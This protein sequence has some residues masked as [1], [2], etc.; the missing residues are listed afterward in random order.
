MFDIKKAIKQWQKTLRKNEAFEDGYIAELESHLRD[1]I[2]NQIS[3]GLNEEKAFD[4]AVLII[5]Q[6]ESIG[7]EFYK[8]HTRHLSGRPPWKPPLFMPELLWNYV[9]VAIRK[10][11]RHK[12][13]SFI[14]ISGLAIGMA[15]CFIVF[16]WVKDELSFDRFHEN[17]P[18]IYRVL[19]NPQDTDIYHPHGPGPLGPTLK[20]DFPEII[21][22][23]RMFGDVNG[24]LKY[25]NEVFNGKVCGVS[26]SFFEIFTFPFVKGDSK[27][28][29]SEPHS[30]VLTEKMAVKLFKDEDPIGKTLG[31]EWWGKWH[32]L[33]VTG[34]IKDV[35]QNSHIQFD[36]LLPFEFVT[37]SGMTIEDWGVGAYKTYVLLPKN[38]NFEEV[39]EKI[40]GTIEKHFPESPRTLYLE[41]L[42]RIHL[43]EFKG[44]GPIA[45]I[46][47]F[48]IIGILILGIACINFMNLSTARSIERAREV[49]MRKVVGSTRAQL[50][51]QFLGE[52]ILLSLISFI[53]A[54]ILVQSLLPYIN[55]I[56]GK[57]LT[58]PY[59]SSPL[60]I[61]LG[62]AAVTGIIS[63]SYP[64]LLLSSFRPTT[65]L[66]GQKRSGSQNISLRKLLVIGQFVVSIVLITGAII[67][68]QQLMYMR[69]MDM[70][71]N[72]KHVINMEL[73]GSLRNKYKI[74]K[75]ELL[76]N[77][78]ILAISATNGSFSK[79]FGS[80]EIGWEGKPEGK[81][82]F[83]YYHS[84]DFDYQKIFDIKMAQGRYF[85]QNYPT[86]ISD[87]II[88]NETAAKIMGM[89]SPIGQQISCWIPFDPKRSG[90]IIGVVKDFHFR[91]LREKINPM[92]LVIAPGWFTDVYIRIKPENVPATLEFLEKTLKELAPDYPLEY[93]FLDEDIDSLYK[94]EQRIGN[95]VKYGTFLAIFIACLG[96]FGLASFTAEKRTKEIGIR[97]VLGASVSGIVLL[98]TKEFIKWVLV[99]NIIALPI[100]Y[101]IMNKWLQNFAYHINIGIWTFLLSAVLALIIALITVSFQAIKTAT[102]NPVESLRYE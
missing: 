23:A 41:P 12:G 99:A 89:E 63:G 21:N 83:M 67:I 33:K 70:G 102:S 19:L 20:S 32:D 62:I 60:L 48:S 4:K 76:R 55:N 59:S 98:L 15:C 36:Y 77:P 80:D 35:P 49:G 65:V 74:I 82:I 69:N 51:R 1:E 14:N 5:G 93:T 11:K 78:D 61:F 17:A 58:L 68:N 56:V 52:S 88:V 24:P 10:I 95:L 84:V 85:S 31:F 90:T 28:C 46:Y 6:A 96:L 100:A 87:G 54:L 9:K 57:Q 39:S 53:F 30:I 16:L 81:R 101:I 27:N 2:Y 64:A 73:R 47:I 38:S 44:G 71:I 45:Y 37:W 43:Y 3:L 91:P 42:A 34:I 97:K 26:P 86:D 22:F 66:K 79:I 29:L 50:I 40:S 94:V 18:E 92:I 13:H 25:K 8:T 7:A 75:K 72:K